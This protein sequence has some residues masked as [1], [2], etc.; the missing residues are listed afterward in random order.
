MKKI[1]IANWKLNGNLKFIKKYFKKLIKYNKY[2]K[3][4][5]ILILIA[6]PIIYLYK[7][8]KIIKKNKNINLISQ[9]IDKNLIGPYTGETSP[10]MLQDIGIKYTLIGHSER[11][12]NHKENN[13]IILKKIILAQKNKIIPILCIGE[14]I[15]DYKNKKSLKI[16]KNQI[17]YI[18]KKNN[19][20]IFKNIIIAYEPIWAIGTGQIANIKHINKINI[21]IK[22][23][24]YKKSKKNIKNIKILYGGSINIKN[25]KKIITQKNIDGLLIGN[26]SL[27]IKNFIKILNI[28]KNNNEKKK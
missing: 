8:K 28:I 3:N 25:I 24:I 1:I 5:K 27:K 9:N 2:N 14:N 21:Y 19:I 16:C 26:Y 4:N 7:I 11:R 17:K 13:K 23:Y 22:N 6:P 18:I 12:K 20:N 10:I 15:K